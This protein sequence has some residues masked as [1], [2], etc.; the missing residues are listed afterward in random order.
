MAELKAYAALAAS[1]TKPSS[2]SEIS[3]GIM[4]AVPGTKESEAWVAIKE[5]IA[6]GLIEKVDSY[7]D[8]AVEI[9]PRRGERV[10]RYGFD[11]IRTEAGDVIT[12]DLKSLVPSR[13]SKYDESDLRAK[14]CFALGKAACKKCGSEDTGSKHES[15]TFPLV[16]VRCFACRLLFSTSSKKMGI[17]VSPVDDRKEDGLTVQRQKK[18]TTHMA[19][20]TKVQLE[21]LT[22]QELVEL[23]NSKAEK[24]VAGFKTKAQGVK[25]ILELTGV[26][27]GKKEKAPKEE[28]EKVPS[29]MS[30][31]R[32]HFKSRK[33]GKLE[34]LCELTGKDAGWIHTAMAILKNPDR[35]GKQGP[36]N[37]TYDR[38]S[39]T[40]TRV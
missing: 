31:I 3:N 2:V 33:T 39:K 24:P 34:E 11:L 5:A 1:K 32:D 19:A 27:N 9:G 17:M 14:Y 29:T 18:G 13:T 37:T 26:A 22:V 4:E 8:G 23:Y 25:A 15:T 28:K 6:E 7:I 30:V 20:K 40:F 35:C 36:V 38:G 10:R 16:A 12:K 21:E